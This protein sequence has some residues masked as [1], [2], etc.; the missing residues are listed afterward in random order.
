[1]KYRDRV[2]LGGSFENL[3]FEGSVFKITFS[4]G[5]IFM[6]F[7][8]EKFQ[9]FFFEEAI[10]NFWLLIEMPADQDGCSLEWLLTGLTAF[11]IAY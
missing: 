3:F 6:L 9:D 2:F 7:L 1:M 4:E 11:Q 10:L 5:A 8:R